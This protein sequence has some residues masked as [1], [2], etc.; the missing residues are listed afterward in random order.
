MRA[1]AVHTAH[2]RELRFRLCE[3]GGG[4]KSREMDI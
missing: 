1:L 2:G 4:K 3:V